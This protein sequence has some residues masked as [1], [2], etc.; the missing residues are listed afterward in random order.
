[1]QRQRPINYVD[2]AKVA[3]KTTIKNFNLNL[4][5]KKFALAPSVAASHRI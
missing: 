3:I 1:M 5:S 4:L 2:F